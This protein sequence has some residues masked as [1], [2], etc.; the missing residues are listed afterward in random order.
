MQQVNKDTDQMKDEEKAKEECIH[1][2]FAWFHFIMY[3]FHVKTMSGVHVFFN[4][5]CIYL[6]I[7]EFKTIF[8]SDNGT[9]RVSH[10][11]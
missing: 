2:R 4:V 9:R 7:M 8:M 10:V 3:D 5:I 1:S 11:E 6:L